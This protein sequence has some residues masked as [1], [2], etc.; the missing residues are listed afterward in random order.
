MNHRRGSSPEVVRIRCQSESASAQNRN[1]TNAP[2]VIRH[3]TGI[4]PHVL[5][6]NT[7][8]IAGVELDIPKTDDSFQAAKNIGS[9]AEIIRVKSALHKGICKFHFTYNYIQAITLL[10]TPRFSRIFFFYDMQ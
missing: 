7:E 8:T 1:G 10:E 2:E 6:K 3:P 5:F 4:Q 9:G